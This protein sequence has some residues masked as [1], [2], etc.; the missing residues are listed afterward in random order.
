MGLFS[1]YPAIADYRYCG[2]Q[3]T[4]PRA[5][6][7]TRAVDCTLT[8]SVSFTWQESEEAVNRGVEY[9]LQAATLGD[10]QAMVYMAKAY[11]T[12]SGLGSLR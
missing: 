2:H 9:M 6:A 8:V 5:S 12:G 7:I 3:M 11:E 1:S 10:R 4:V